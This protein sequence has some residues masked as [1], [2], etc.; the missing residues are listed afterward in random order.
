MALPFGVVDEFEIKAT[1]HPTEPDRIWTRATMAPCSFIA[2]QAVSRLGYARA[3]VVNTYGGHRSEP[4][5]VAEK[6]GH[7]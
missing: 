3:E 4:L 7:V 6:L 1:G 5:Y 2:D